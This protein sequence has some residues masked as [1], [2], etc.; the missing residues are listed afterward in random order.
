[1]ALAAA[2]R[3]ITTGAQQAP[4]KIP[5]IGDLMGADPDD[6]STKFAAFRGALEKLGYTDGQTVLIEPRYAM[7]PARSV[8]HSGTRAGGWRLA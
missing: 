6:E 4:A 7:G 3:P 1:L 5:R 8:R 2:T